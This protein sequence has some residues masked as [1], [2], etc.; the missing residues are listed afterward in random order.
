[1]RTA[2]LF[3]NCALAGS[4][5]ATYPGSI[6]S[7]FYAAPL[8]YGIVTYFPQG[9]TYGDGYLW[10]IY[11]EGIVTKRQFP[12]GSLIATFV[13]PAPA[14]GGEIAWDSPRKYI[15]IRSVYTGVYWVDSRTGSIMGF[16]PKPAGAAAL[17]GIEYDD[18]YSGRPIWVGD[19]HTVWNLNGAG[20]IVNSFETSSWPHRP[21][22]YA[23]DSDSAGGPYL[24]V[25]AG[26]PAVSP[27]I[28]V[29]DPANFSVI[30]SFV[31]P[32]YPASLADITWD[33][34]YLWG[35]ESCEAT[36][37]WVKRFVVYS[38]PAVAPASLGQVKAL[39]R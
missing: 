30:N 15:F 38:S 10:V 7:S 14:W 8:T 22:T 11:A 19:G 16:F 39:Y 34:Q 1:M 13:C 28:Y 12:S 26:R 23:S 27:W 2:L 36:V 9:L 35:L 5:L 17:W 4:A 25:G 32:L 31:S 6:I 33:G 18:Y 24:L 29:V 21:L 20:S 3:I 37:G